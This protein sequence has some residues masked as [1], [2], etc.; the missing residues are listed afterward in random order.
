VHFK[1][2]DDVPEL[3]D[4]IRRDGSRVYN[5]SYANKSLKEVEHDALSFASYAMSPFEYSI[6]NKILFERFILS[7]KNTQKVILVLSPYHPKLFSYLEM[8]SPHFSRIENEVRE[9][10]REHNIL[11][12]GSYN[13][14]VSGCAL[15]EFYDG[16]HPTPN[17]INRMLEKF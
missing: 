9:F 2:S 11:V 15:D 4:K 6:E 12:V 1:A 10:A 8:H 3:I 5:V 13:P 16:M 17:C 7:I 14:K